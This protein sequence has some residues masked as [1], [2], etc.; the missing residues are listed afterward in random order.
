MVASNKSTL[1]KAGIE[2]SK[3]VAD[4]EAEVRF[5]VIILMM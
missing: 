1:L 5:G 3:R 2:I 4:L